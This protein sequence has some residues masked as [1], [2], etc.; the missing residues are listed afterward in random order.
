MSVTRLPLELVHVIA[1]DVD[2]PLDL[3]N[4]R[5]VSKDLNSKIT[6]VALRVIVVNDS[7]KSAKAVSFLQDCHESITS[8]VQEVVFQGDPENREP[9][10]EPGR[11]ALKIVFSG[12]TKFCNLQKLRLDLHD[13]WDEDDPEESPSHYLL[14]QNEIFAALAVNPPPS[15]TSLT[16]NNV[17][18]I[19]HNIYT[20]ENFQRVFLSVRELNISVLSDAFLEGNYCDESLG[21]F[22]EQSV[23]PMVRI[24]IAVTALTI[25]SDQLIGPCSPSLD[26]G[27]II[28]PHL[29]SLVLRQIDIQAT[30]A[31]DFILSHKAMLTRLELHESAMDGGFREML[32]PFGG[33]GA[34]FPRP[35]HVV[36]ASFEAE[37]GVL[38]EFV[39]ESSDAEE[40]FERF[41]YTYQD[42]GFG[43]I[44][45][46]EAAEAVG[47]LDEPALESL[48]AVVNSR[49]G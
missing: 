49:R 11:D 4:L 14:L 3:V 21:E 15:L 27:D 44:P 30:G 36:F 34:V 19:S 22:W 6:P 9:S 38:R 33:F 47:Q 32:T 10:E 43:Y 48:M 2:G 25:E 42:P 24:A 26:L 31:E 28:L 12:L 45:W 29:S 5:L 46:E 8:L 37:L 39:F 13:T 41:K 40:R 35:W 23:T 1:R 17:I 18:A 7:V 16:L 20:Q